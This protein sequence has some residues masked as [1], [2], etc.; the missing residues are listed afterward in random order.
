MAVRAV[1]FDLDNTLLLEDE[2]THAAL[3]RASERAG[4]RAEAVAAAAAR[5][6]ADLFRSSPVFA[7]A[8]AIGIWWGEALW[9]G[10]AGDAA[11]L[12]AL[13][14]F[15][16]GY[17][18]AVWTAALAAAEVTDVGLAAELDAAFV[19]ARRSDW[20][21]DPAALATVDETA[22]H[23]RLALVTNG[24]PDVQR[25]KLAATGIGS[26]VGTVIIAGELGIGKPDRRIFAA[27][28]AAIGVAADEAVMVGD[29]LERDIA[30]ARGAG[31]RAIWLDRA[32]TPADGSALADG[33]A[34]PDVRIVRLG[35]LEAALAA[36]E[37]RV[38]TFDSA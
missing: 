8:D 30:G 11:G 38:P 20:A 25:E 19:R 18:R 5:T 29:S 16:P 34:M 10:F 27:A 4:P 22:R 7:Y 35:E 36:I 13:R 9:G 2:A 17:R 32:P 31:L 1:L 15:V 23:Y 3:R 28:L 33:S 12:R 26:R 14:A 6:A 37:N 21:I 24:A